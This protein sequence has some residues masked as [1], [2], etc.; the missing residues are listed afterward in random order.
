MASYCEKMQTISPSE[1]SYG[2]PPI[3][4]HALS[5]YWSCQEVLLLVYNS[6]SLNFITFFIFLKLQQ[7]RR[8]RSKRLNLNT[9][10]N[11]FILFLNCLTKTAQK[12]SRFIIIGKC[13]YVFVDRVD[14]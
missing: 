7:S 5:L 6:C 2:R 9:Y 14:I 1:R 3:K 13:G 10:V 12:H 11:G 8:N 4:T